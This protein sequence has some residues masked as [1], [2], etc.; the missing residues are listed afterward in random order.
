MKKIELEG[1]NN[2]YNF[3][4]LRS[5]TTHITKYSLVLAEKFYHFSQDLYLEIPF[6]VQG[7][8]MW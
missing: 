6:F 1:I 8:L 3:K 4:V 7:K 2:L 5:H